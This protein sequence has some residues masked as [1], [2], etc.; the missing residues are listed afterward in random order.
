MVIGDAKQD[1]IAAQPIL[2][3]YLDVFRSVLTAGDRRL[4]CVGYSFSDHHINAAIREGLRKG[5]RLYVL[6]PEPPDSLATRLNL[7]QELGEE[8]WGGLVGY[9]QYD[10]RT[11]FPV[12][13]SITAD[14][15]MIQGRFFGRP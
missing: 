9:F 14:L 5:L 10:L 12:D 13:Q 2:A 1:Q 15:T 6:S 8:I 11:L 7:Q 4:L 3:A